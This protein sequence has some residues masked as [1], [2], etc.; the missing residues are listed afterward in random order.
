[1]TNLRA[2]LLIAPLALSTAV[3]AQPVHL[4]DAQYIATARCQALMSSANLGRQDTHAID[5]M[6]KSESA[7]RTNGVFDRAEAARDEVAQA[8]RHA[9]A[10]TKPQLIAERDGFCRSLTGATMSAS[11][12]TAGATRAN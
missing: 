3:M 1:M 9:G 7:T 2:L 12:A 5:A 4:S 10:Y 8:A 6:M 11:A